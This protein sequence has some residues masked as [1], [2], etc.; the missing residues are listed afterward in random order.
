MA[1]T[2]I[3]N[4]VEEFSNTVGTGNM[5]LTGN[6]IG[7]ASFDSQCQDGELVNCTVKDGANKETGL[8]TFQAPNIL[9]RTNIYERLYNGL[10]TDFPGAP[11]PLSGQAKVII[12][13]SEQY[14]DRRYGADWVLTTV[15]I[16]AED[17]ANIL[18]DTSGG[19]VTVTLPA[20]PRFG[21]KIAFADYA[22]TFATNNLILARNG[23]LIEGLA[24]DM[25]VDINKPTLILLYVDN[26][27]GWVRVPR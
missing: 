4:W 16:P 24:E 17:G 8:F 2:K 25:A 6:T 22:S 13:Q 20:S 1:T 5:L 14:I 3:R 26:N 12:C 9:I 10:I 11:M 23:S 27:K 7:Y 18:V 21:E 15:N 19:P